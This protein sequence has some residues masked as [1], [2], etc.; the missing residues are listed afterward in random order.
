MNQFRR[1]GCDCGGNN[2]PTSPRALADFIRDPVDNALMALRTRFSNPAQTETFRRHF[3][4][5][6]TC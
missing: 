1:Q 5:T 6:N 3:T 4:V 2:L